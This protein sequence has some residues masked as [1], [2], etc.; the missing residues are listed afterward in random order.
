MIYLYSA[1]GLELE[2]QV[3]IPGLAETVPTDEPP[4][5]ARIS[6]AFGEPPSWR[7]GWLKSNAELVF[8]SDARQKQ[9]PTNN[10]RVYSR[11]NGAAFHLT[12]PDGAQ[13]VID[14]QTEKIWCWGPKSLTS[15]DLGTYIVGPVL[16]FILRRRGALALHA[17]CF[18]FRGHAF[19]LSGGPQSGKS[20]MAAALA[21]RGMSILCED[22]T[23]LRERAG[24]FLA[25]SGYP[26]VN[27][28]P[29]SAE[30]VSG[31]S[32]LPR[33]TPNWEKQFL[34]LDGGRTS[35]E[36]HP[37]PLAAVYIIAPREASEA[38]PRIEAIGPRNA[39]LLL[40]QNTYMNYLLDKAQRAAEF[41]SL[42]RLASRLPVRRLVPHSALAGISSV[43]ELIET[44]VAQVL[45]TRDAEQFASPSSS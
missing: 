31:S 10:L 28:W 41:D 7:Q 2:S 34:P 37:R 44:D 32:E 4:G 43:C 14:A 6:V 33:I 11:D 35:F 15:E 40:V 23:A 3:A 29:D 42:V 12:Y 24:N 19:A 30:S 26:R 8:P 16:G 21:L 45:S 36:R 39:T 5:S 1:Y 25:S 17:S 38:A 22:I 9:N 18:C 13:F 27:L 20:T